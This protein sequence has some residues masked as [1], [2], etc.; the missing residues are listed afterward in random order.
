ME[1][2][3]EI[4]GAAQYR[5]TLDTTTTATTTT[6]SLHIICLRYDVIDVAVIPAA[7]AFVYM[8]LVCV[9]VCVLARASVS[10][11]FV[12]VAMARAHA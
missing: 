3:L 1:H 8:S 11:E 7:H 10:W 2:T 4:A 12:S 5:C 9:F 6:H